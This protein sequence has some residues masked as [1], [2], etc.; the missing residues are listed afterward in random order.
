MFADDSLSKENPFR[1]AIYLAGATAS[2]KTA[3]GVSLAKKIDAE[4]IALDA[5]TLYRGLDIGTAKPSVDEREGIPHHLIDVLDPWEASSVADYLSWARAAIFDIESRGKRVLFV[6]GTPMYLKML[7]RGLFE[8]P[9][10]DPDL[11]QSLEAV[12]D[13]SGDVALLE[14]L[15][16]VDPK[17][18]TRLHVN[19]RRRI[20]RALEVYILTGRPLSEFQTEHDR[21]AEGVAAFAIDRDVA[22]LRSRIDRRVLT[23]FDLGLLD[24]VRR[25]L[26]L[27]YP[28]SATSSQ[29]VG[30]RESID[31]IS[32]RCSLAETI[33]LIQART[34][35]FSKRQRTWFRSL[36]EVSPLPVADSEFSETIAE[37]LVEKLRTNR[38]VRPFV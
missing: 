16:L 11:R 20:I 34:R 5:L 22:E 10:A 7:L 27:P 30:Y 15:F 32:G 18:A 36:S 21:P 25:L 35:Q 1:R 24:E 19:D 17:T 38:F 29:A 9:A 6:G 3:I 2:G 13:R 12:A 23:M 4:I 28:L 14:R 26:S 8:G 33:S 31:H 37:R